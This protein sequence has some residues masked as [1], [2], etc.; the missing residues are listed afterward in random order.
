MSKDWSF[1]HRYHGKGWLRG[2]PSFNGRHNRNRVL[3][4]YVLYLYWQLYPHG[5]GLTSKEIVQ[6]TGLGSSSVWPT[7]TKSLSLRFV[8]A[9]LHIGRIAHRYYR[10]DAKGIQ[11]LRN[12]VRYIPWE[13]YNLDEKGRWEMRL[14]MEALVKARGFN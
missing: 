3:I 10:V 7:L 6:L 14:K 5:R 4:Y 11:W 2:H 8:S 13:K 9:Y 12:W 1:S